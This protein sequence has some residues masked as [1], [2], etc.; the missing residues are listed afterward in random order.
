MFCLSL[1]KPFSFYFSF[2][3]QFLFWFDSFKY[4][5]LF[6]EILSEL[7]VVVRFREGKAS[8]K[9]P[10]IYVLKEQTNLGLCVKKKNRIAIFVLVFECGSSSLNMCIALPCLETC[11][12]RSGYLHWMSW[13]IYRNAS[14]QKIILLG[15]LCK[16]KPII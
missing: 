13:S 1:R 10:K 16:K 5:R 9:S 2:P 3:L 6:W 12:S 8:K 7:K 14:L 15:F 4:F 11:S